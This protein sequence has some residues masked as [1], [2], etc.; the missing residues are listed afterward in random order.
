ML[1]SLFSFALFG[2]YGILGIHVL[3]GSIQHVNHGFRIVLVNKEQELSGSE[4]IGKGCD[5]DF[6]V[7][8]VN[9]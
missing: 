6:I 7:S 8:F 3:S 4:S 1:F 5:Q 9:Q 2:S